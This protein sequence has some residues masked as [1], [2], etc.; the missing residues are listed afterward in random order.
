MLGGSTRKGAEDTYSSLTD[1]KLPLTAA[2]NWNEVVS[3]A[4][5]DA[6]QI[7]M[8]L[9]LSKAISTK[10]L[11]SFL[12][13]VL[14]S[15]LFIPESCVTIDQIRSVNTAA[16][17]S[18]R[19]ILSSFNM[20][21]IGLHSLFSNQRN[22]NTI[23]K[24]ALVNPIV[25]EPAALTD[26]QRSRNK[27][28]ALRDSQSLWT[29]KS[30]FP[31][32]NFFI[33]RGLRAT[34]RESACV[35]FEIVVTVY[36]GSSVKCTTGISD[37]SSFDLAN[38]LYFDV[39]KTRRALRVGDCEAVVCSLS[40]QDTRSPRPFQDWKNHLAYFMHPVLFGYSCNSAKRTQKIILKPAVVLTLDPLEIMSESAVETLNSLGGDVPVYISEAQ[41]ERDRLQ[42]CGMKTSE[43]SVEKLILLQSL[44]KNSER[45]YLSFVANKPK[46]I[47][48]ICKEEQFLLA[49]KVAAT[50]LLRTAQKVVAERN[51]K[52]LKA[53]RKKEF[54]ASFHESRTIDANHNTFEG[55]KPKIG[56]IQARKMTHSLYENSTV[57]D[58][59]KLLRQRLE[60]QCSWIVKYLS[61]ESPSPLRVEVSYR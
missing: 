49:R 47:E 3:P 39:M 19:P 38:Y 16:T 46:G 44:E 10:L 20:L 7:K 40:F 51:L 55:K 4:M 23:L 17:A 34:M 18:D 21:P 11:E 32:V 14:A 1:L 33:K 50:R 53:G 57:R 56:V 5:L 2:V 52:T 31:L 58:R 9:I 13:D 22:N 45:L 15:I 61:A 12:R 29:K 27:I 24:K 42:C 28:K 59:E 35:R 60:G 30:T 48:G 8:N 37:L 41:Q 43:I 36:A 26:K 25:N 54:Q 6:T